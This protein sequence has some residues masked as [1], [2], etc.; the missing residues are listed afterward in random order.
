MR[1]HRLVNISSDD[2]QKV[3]SEVDSVLARRAAGELGT[4][5]DWGT[6]AR[7]IVEYW[8]DRISHMHTYL[9]N[10]S[11]PSVNTTASLPVI[12]TLAYTPVEGG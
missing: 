10:A 8:G 6:T 5:F 1:S 4:N 3:V 11:D 12:R 9:L 2:A 7:S